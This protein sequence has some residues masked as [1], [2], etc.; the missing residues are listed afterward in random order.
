MII[1]VST[2]HQHELMGALAGD[3]DE[4]TFPG[5][6]PSP[7]GTSA[8]IDRVQILEAFEVPQELIF[9]VSVVGSVILGVVS[10]WLYEVL[11]RG[12]PDSIEINRRTVTLTK[13]EVTKI[14]EEEIRL[15]NR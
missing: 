2:R 7:D 9:S 5:P 3:Q 6:I 1:R 13:G 4:L 12:D 11:K 8:R 15:H 10:N 14:V